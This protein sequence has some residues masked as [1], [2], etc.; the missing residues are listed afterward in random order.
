MAKSIL[1]PKTDFF[2]EGE[3]KWHEAY[4]KLRTIITEC[5]LA[6]E[7]KWGKPC[8]THDNKNIVLIQGFKDY[9]AL[10]FFKG[11]LLKD[12]DNILNKIGE[13]TQAA[14]QLRFN[15]AKEINSRKAQ[16][17]AYIFEAIAVEKAGLKV[18]LRKSTELVYPEEFKAALAKSPALKKA[19]LALSPGR[20]NAYNYFF[21]SPKLSKTRATRVENS[22]AQILAGKG[23]ND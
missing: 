1:N 20:Q 12:E 5:Q 21:S 13:N 8:Y 10:L 15:N 6:E 18:V 2:F 11:A 9:C 22:I 17:K 19:F 14:R 23:L 3:S 16:I 4:T 7:L